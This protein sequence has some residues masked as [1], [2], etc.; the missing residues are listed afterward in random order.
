MSKKNFPSFGDMETIL[1]EVN[2]KIDEK[3][4]A[5]DTFPED[6]EVGDK[7]L[8][9]GT[10]GDNAIP[11]HVY[12]LT[13]E[14]WEDQTTNDG[15]VEENGLVKTNKGGIYSFGGPD[16]GYHANPYRTS[17]A[18]SDTS[19]SSAFV[20][21]R[22][23]KYASSAPSQPIANADIGSEVFGVIDGDNADNKMFAGCAAIV[24]GKV[25]NGYDIT[26]TNSGAIAI[27]AARKGSVKALEIGA[28]ATGQDTRANGHGAHAEGSHTHAYSDHSHAEGYNTLAGNPQQGIYSNSGAHAEGR[29]TFATAEA[30][31]AEGRRTEARAN[32]THAE[33][34]LTDAYGISSHAENYYTRT[35]GDYSHAEGHTTRATQEASHA[36]GYKTVCFAKWG[37]TEGNATLAYGEDV[38]GAHAEG[39]RTLAHSGAHAEG[40]NTEASGYGAHAEGLYTYT[41]GVACHAEGKATRAT[42]Y[43]S[44][45]EGVRTIANYSGAHSGGLSGSQ[46]TLIK[47]PNTA[48]FA[49]GY[50][51]SD[52]DYD[53]VFEAL[54][55]GS[56]LFGVSAAYYAYDAD[57]SIHRT[58]GMASFAAGM[59]LKTLATAQAAFGRFNVSNSSADTHILTVG[60]GA[61]TGRANAFRV[62]STAVYGAGAYNSSG[63][64]Y[65]EMFEWY[66]GNPDKEDRRG[67]F[68]TIHKNMIMFA[69]DS[70]VLGIVSADPSVCGDVHDDQW[71]DMYLRDIF[72]APIFEEYEEE[73]DTDKLDENGERIKATRIQKRQVI[74]PDYDPN[75]EYIPRSERPE[76]AAVGMLGKLVMVDDGTS[77]PG[78]YVEPTHDKENLG[79]A[80]KA[81]IETRFYCMERL[82]ETHIRV[83]IK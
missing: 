28:S 60:K 6:A 1:T 59:N 65:A 51:Q 57:L 12:M 75:I 79:A 58:T 26:A 2:E 22:V 9:T 47:A 14:D 62:A 18:N 29:D 76:W 8:Y 55:V 40:M 82:D 69:V 50:L 54:G 24:G 80:T 81:E 37:H 72:G 42:G 25:S 15:S 16:T 19:K 70:P 11:G 83:L 56:T 34:E 52:G 71:K 48:S 41:S 67:R 73:Y 53:G 21:V 30:S 10:A 33:G 68:V 61:N 63:A 20:H 3:V 7:I 32:Y 39:N 78:W 13:E 66:D 77:E 44:H 38:G 64:D 43:Y 35:L 49:H 36:E 23:Y 27:G 5:S 46:K 17:F 45:A 31:H 74:N 4:T